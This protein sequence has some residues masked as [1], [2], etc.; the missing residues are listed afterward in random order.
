MRALDR[1]ESRGF[2]LSLRAFLTENG[3]RQFSGTISTGSVDCSW[4]LGLWQNGTWAAKGDFHDGGLVLGDFFALDFLLD[5]DHGIGA[6]LTGSILDP[7]ESRHTSVSRNGNDPWLRDHWDRIATS[8]PTVLLHAAPA[9]GGLV[10]FV[11]IGIIA[12]AEVLFGGDNGS[13]NGMTQTPCSGWP[14]APGSQD[15][16]CVHVTLGPGGS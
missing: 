1:L 4:V 9:V 13:A 6:T 7:V 14:D 5:S 11:V 15:T 12:A 2:P 16:T 3:V 10:T 8:G